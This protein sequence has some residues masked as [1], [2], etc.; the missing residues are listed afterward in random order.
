MCSGGRT[1]G[2]CEKGEPLSGGVV[3][4]FGCFGCGYDLCSGCHA[5]RAKRKGGG[6]VKKYGKDDGKASSTRNKVALSVTT[7]AW[8]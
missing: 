5:K 4:R 6:R 1:Q 8:C 2:G 7:D 3:A